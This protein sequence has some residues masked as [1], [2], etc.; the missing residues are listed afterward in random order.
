MLFKIVWKYI[1][2]GD[3]MRNIF[4]IRFILIFFN[5]WALFSSN[6]VNQAPY[7]PKTTEITAEELQG[8]RDVQIHSNKVVT[9]WLG[10]ESTKD[11]S[12]LS[13]PKNYT[14]I[15]NDDPDFKNGINPTNVFRSSNLSHMSIDSWTSSM[16]NRMHCFVGLQFKPGKNYKVVLNKK[17]L[18]NGFNLQRGFSIDDTPNPSFKLNQVGYSNLTNKKYIY[19]SSYLGDGEPID[20]SQFTDFSIKKEDDNTVVFTGIID[21]VSKE[22]FQGNDEL[23]RLDIS[24]FKEEG[25]FYAYIKGFGRSYPF[26][27]GREASNKVYEI[28]SLGMYCQRSGTEI[29]KSIAG[30]W[31]RPMAHNNIYVTKKN[32]SNPWTENIYTYVPTPPI[33]PKSD[34]TQWYDPD[35]PYEFH[36]GHYDAAD[37]DIRLSHVGVAERLLSLYESFPNKFKDNQAKIPETGNG[38]PDILDEA[39]WSLLAWEYLQDYATDIRGLDGGIPSGVETFAHPVAGKMGHNDPYPFWMKKVTPYSSFAGAAV[40]AQAARVFRDID[41]NR[42]ENYLTRAKRAYKYALD[43]VNEKWEP[44]TIL[45]KDTEIDSV[46]ADSAYNS[47]ELKCMQAWAAGQL[48]STTG[49]KEYLK[50]FNKSKS[51]VF[52]MYDPISLTLDKWIILWPIISTKQSISNRIK[53]EVIDLLLSNA[54]QKLL[55]ARSNGNNGYYST[56]SNSGW[57]GE[58]SPLNTRSINSVVRSYMLTKEQ[59]YLDAISTS[60][61]FVLG[62]NPSERSWMTG[63]GSV[64]PMNP[65]NINCINDDVIEPYPG[66]VIM[67]PTISEYS[68]D[69]GD[70]MY[71]DPSKM[72]LYRKFVD[73]DAYCVEQCEY[74]VHEDQISLY[75][76]AGLLLDN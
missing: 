71:P 74:T 25:K 24:S 61:D 51:Y 66:I 23:Y 53:T 46:Q 40:F 19:L 49:K 69:K 13:N 76:A 62:M 16:D 11:V 37:F 65:L 67:G 36:G 59:K 72:G 57:F 22:D 63:A 32:I 35:G 50:D 8:F 42:A 38:I 27:N 10:Y 15:S 48:F 60:L 55:E 43:H 58:A 2:K 29:K 33:D 47:Q 41:K 54:E 28:I 26:L 39:S 5:S 18:P 7:Y 1:F 6:S 70:F 4:S 45:T 68:N 34:S 44:L 21:F 3:F 56:C 12:I 14:I 20:L 52:S 9:A 30:D 75:I 73:A 31:A 17:L 64:Y